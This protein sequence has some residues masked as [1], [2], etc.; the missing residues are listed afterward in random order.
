MR[1]SFP[2]S[3]FRLGFLYALLAGCT[4]KSNPDSLQGYSQKSVRLSNGLGIVSV[5]LP[6]ALDTFYTAVNYGEYH[7]AEVKL[8]RFASRKYDCCLSTNSDFQY[9]DLSDS[10]YQF[11]IIQTFNPDCE[12]YITVNAGLMNT[13]MEYYKSLDAK[14][15]AQR[16]FYLKDINGKHFI[17]SELSMKIDSLQLNELDG[18][19]DA[20]GR[21]VK[22]IYK[23]YCRNPG[24]FIGQMTESLK[25]INIVPEGQP[26][27]NTN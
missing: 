26:P 25:T 9:S 2:N 4:V 14:A 24:D 8:H 1:Y 12:E 3:A 5:Y 22:F 16:K 18:F 23:C 6:A 7:C 20:N 10:I 27:V 13:I 21:L 11:T 15:S 17:I 19:T